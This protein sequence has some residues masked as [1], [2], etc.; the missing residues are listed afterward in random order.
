MWD[1]FCRVPLP[2]SSLHT[3]QRGQRQ[4]QCCTVSS[5]A[6]CLNGSLPL[7]SLASSRVLCLEGE[8]RE[9]AAAAYSALI[10]TTSQS[11][12]TRYGQVGDKYLEQV[13]S[14]PLLGQLSFS[15]PHPWSC[16]ILGTAVLHQRSC[17]G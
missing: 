6:P 11:E 13:G 17:L 8:L 15:P 7:G 16:R 1:I 2:C 3:A 14:D 4:A 12:R 5:V 9:D 10:C